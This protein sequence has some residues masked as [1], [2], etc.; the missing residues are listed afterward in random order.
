MAGLTQTSAIPAKAPDFNANAEPAWQVLTFA[1]GNEQFGI[2]ILKV[3]EIRGWSP[4]TKLPHVPAHVLGVLNLRGAIVPI[5]DMRVRFQLPQ[6]EFTPLTVIIV[7]TASSSRGQ[8]EFG[9]VVDG[10]A[11]VLDID[12]SNLKEM[13]NLGASPASEFIQGLAVARERMLI[14]L[15]VAELIR[16][17][18]Q[19]SVPASDHVA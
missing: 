9:L 1:L 13:P 6:A 15:N 2:D 8:R 12:A 19:V 16:R 5:I 11:E 3:Q 10:V 7:L 4:V 17:D 18:M 14:L